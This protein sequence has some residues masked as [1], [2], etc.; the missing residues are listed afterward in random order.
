MLFR[1][2]TFFATL[3]MASLIWFGIRYGIEVALAR[4]QRR[5]HDNDWDRVIA[6]IKLRLPRNAEF[7]VLEHQVWFSDDRNRQ[8]AKVILAANGF[9]A[10]ETETYE[11]GTKY[12]LLTWRAT[13]LDNVK[14][15]IGKV[16]GFVKEY[17][18]RYSGLSLR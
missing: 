11:K 7:A 13:V 10:S 4:R 3:A 17:G 1:S 14:V 12:W 15:E 5:S 6:S 2:L 8:A 16:A 18:G 9:D